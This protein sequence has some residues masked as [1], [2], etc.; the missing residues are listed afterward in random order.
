[1]HTFGYGWDLSLL[2]NFDELS[3]YFL[4]ILLFALL[5]CFFFLVEYFEYDAGASTI[6]F[7]SAAF[8]QVA[9]LYFCA[10]DL[11]MLLFL[12]EVISLISFFLIQHWSFRLVS[13]KAGLKVFSVSQVGDLPFF[14]FCFLLINQTGVTDLAELTLAFP[15]YAFEYLRVGGLLVHQASLLVLCLQTAVLLKAAQ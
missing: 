10:F 14:L 5:L 15:L 9:L 11:Y 8:S 3:A 2:L 13:F 1:M 4:A 7:L 12:W 6:I